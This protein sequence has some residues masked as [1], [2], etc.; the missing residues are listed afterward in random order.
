MHKIDLLSCKLSFFFL[1]ELLYVG[2]TS[3]HIL[4]RDGSPG[5]KND[6]QLLG[7]ISISCFE[8]YD[9]L[10]IRATHETEDAQEQVDFRTFFE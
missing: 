5:W 2:S 4:K 7:L 1:K 6:H 3:S 8:F 10:G 9:E